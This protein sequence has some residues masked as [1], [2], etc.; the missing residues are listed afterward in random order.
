MFT[1]KYTAVETAATANSGTGPK[2]AVKHLTAHNVSL[3]IF[4]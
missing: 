2:I 4:R 1:N 3:F